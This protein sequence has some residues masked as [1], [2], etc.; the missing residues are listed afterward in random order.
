MAILLF[1]YRNRLLLWRNAFY[2]LR[3]TPEII[4]QAYSLMNQGILIGGKP[5][6]RHHI[7][8]IRPQSLVELR[9][10]GALILINPE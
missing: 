9:Y 1:R 3:S 5:L 4:I 2:F 6:N 7:F 8:N 10:F